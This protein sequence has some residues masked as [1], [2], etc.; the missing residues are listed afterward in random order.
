[1]AH[2]AGTVK[3]IRW[4]GPYTDGEIPL[5]FNFKWAETDINFSGFGI[6]ATLLDDDGVERAFGGSV[7][8][9]DIATGLVTVSFG[10]TDVSVPAGTL[11][12]TRRLQIWTGDGGT[13]LVA[14]TVVKYNCHPAIGTPPAI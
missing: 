4:A 11:L 8:F 12:L 10:A 5:P 9:A 14:S 2:V 6:D 1:M 3:P 7:T 13:N